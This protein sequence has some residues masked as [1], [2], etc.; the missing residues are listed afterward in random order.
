[1]KGQFTMGSLCFKDTCGVCGVCGVCD[2]CGVCGVCG[3]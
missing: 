2:V 3:S 1:M